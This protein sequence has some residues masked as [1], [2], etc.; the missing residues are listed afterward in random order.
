MQQ[1]LFVSF[2]VLADPRALDLTAAQLVV[3][4]ED[5]EGVKIALQNLSRDFSRVTG[6]TPPSVR[7]HAV[8]RTDETVHAQTAIIVGCIE[9]SKLLQDLERSGKVDF[10]NIR[11]RWESF[12]T[13]VVEGPLCGYEKA[14]VIAGSNKRGAIYGVYALSEQIGVSPYVTPLS[15]HPDQNPSL[16]TSLA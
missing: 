12:C 3:D 6:K 10:S 7:H 13:T 2:S 11:G 4:A 9:S 8:A 5:Y 15:S 1:E 14:L 16:V